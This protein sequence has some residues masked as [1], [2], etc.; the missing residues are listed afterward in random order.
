MFSG[1]FVQGALNALA[2]FAI[3]C[4]QADVTTYCCDA[5]AGA[6]YQA[7]LAGLAAQPDVLRESFEEGPWV[8]ARTIPQPSVSN[9]GF[10]WSRLDAGLLTSTTGRGSGTLVRT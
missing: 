5:A 1:K 8:A 2:L 4:V 9:P 7:D 10:T 6:A 3:P